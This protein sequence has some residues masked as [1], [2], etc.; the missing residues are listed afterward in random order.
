MCFFCVIV[1]LKNKNM[2]TTSSTT[3]T[4][5]PHFRT[6]LGASLGS[7]LGFPE[8]FRCGLTHNVMTDPVTTLNGDTYERSAIEDWINR[9]GKC[10]MTWAPLS[11]ADLAPNLALRRIIERTMRKRAG[12]TDRAASK[13]WSPKKVGATLASMMYQHT[14]FFTSDAIENKIFRNVFS[15][16]VDRDID[17]QLLRRQCKLFH[18]V[19]QESLSPDRFSV[20]VPRDFKTLQEAVA[21]WSVSSCTNPFEI[22]LQPGVHNVD[23]LTI[24]TGGSNCGLTIR[25][26]L[27]K[28]DGQDHLVRPALQW[29][30]TEEKKNEDDSLTWDVS[31]PTQTSP[32]MGYFAKKNRQRKRNNRKSSRNELRLQCELRQRQ[33]EDQRQYGTVC[34]AG[35]TNVRFV[36]LRFDRI[37]VEVEKS[38]RPPSHGCQTFTAAEDLTV[39]Q[40]VYARWKKRNT[41][42]GDETRSR[43]FFDCFWSHGT[44]ASC[45]A[46]ST[47][48]IVVDDGQLKSSIAPR[49]I[50]TKQHVSLLRCGSSSHWSDIPLV[51]QDSKQKVAMTDCFP[52]TF[53]ERNPG[54]QGLWSILRERCDDIL[55]LMRIYPPAQIVAKDLWAEYTTEDLWYNQLKTRA[56]QEQWRQLKTRAAQEQRRQRATKFQL[57]KHHKHH[58]VRQHRSKGKDRQHYQ[59]KR[60]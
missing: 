27:S 41:I 9:N 57:R 22:L 2:S 1:S 16:H 56:A 46:D 47:F 49:D 15:F 44:V 31:I 37:R 6:S 28:D 11:I 32:A 5:L 43:F 30:I 26:L 40:K 36:D 13:S 60:K 20:V 35:T 24:R 52:S 48:D 8:E 55:G 33:H 39:G 38:S 34:V 50:R 10:P 42:P 4:V 58:V 17:A 19:V 45:N 18:D 53:N 25:G 21:A 29:K 3:H 7:S 59:R 12:K 51:A 23:M 14:G 54:Y